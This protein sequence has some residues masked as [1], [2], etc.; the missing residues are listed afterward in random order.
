VLYNILGR[1]ETWAKSEGS[2]LGER[3]LALFFTDYHYCYYYMKI[4][5]QIT[6]YNLFHRFRPFKIKILKIG[7][8]NDTQ[9]GI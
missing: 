7:P 4:D 9:E 8:R 3:G 5:I 6:C 2:F 1:K